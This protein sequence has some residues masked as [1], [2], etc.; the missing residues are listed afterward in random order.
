MNIT[1][2]TKV[3]AIFGDPIGHTLSP[4]IQNAA[5][6][7]LALDMVYV[8]FHVRPDDLKS[9][10]ESI[11]S[12][13]I[14][15]V[16]TTI[17]HK[18]TVM[19]YLDEVTEEARRIGAV[20]TIVNE[21]GRLIGHNT[22]GAGY[23]KSLTEETGF[24]CKGKNLVIL[25]A[26]GAARGIL[27][28]LMNEG[29]A[30]VTITNRSADR[31]ERLA[32]DI[33]TFNPYVDV[34][35]VPLEKGP[36]KPFI[37]RADLLLNTTSLGM[38]GNPP[39]NPLVLSLDSLKHGAVVSDIVYRPYETSLLKSAKR[40]LGSEAK[41]LKLHRGL[42]MLICQGALGFELWTG[43]TAPVEAMWKAALEA[44]EITLK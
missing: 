11:R 34:E 10:V 39:F 35:F 9:A 7:E 5:I 38:Q 29:P 20:N 41:G 23:L 37:E 33:A 4:A 14:G 15:G 26:G 3:L 16:N 36:L 8:P 30:T 40:A 6:E 13:N 25:G 43:K 21:E 31:A 28:A 18:E 42:G 27:S 12:L 44:L 19:Q 24:S 32:E 17:P 1:Q 2:D 22:D